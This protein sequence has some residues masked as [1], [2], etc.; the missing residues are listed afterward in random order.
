MSTSS[1][2]TNTSLRAGVAWPPPGN[3]E[4]RGRWRGGRRSGWQRRGAKGAT[5]VRRGFSGVASGAMIDGDV[6][7]RFACGVAGGAMTGGS[8]AHGTNWSPLSRHVG[9]RSTSPG[10]MG[11]GTRQTMA[12]A[13][14]ARARLV[15]LI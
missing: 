13:A 8:Q 1:S 11:R 6:G 10:V 5:G 14:A 9:W 7:V 15:F 3:L 4:P 2:S 12:I